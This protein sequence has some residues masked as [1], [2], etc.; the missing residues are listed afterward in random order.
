MRA[1]R[2]PYGGGR[3]ERRGFARDWGRV[4]A[5]WDWEG[6]WAF[7]VDVG[8]KRRIAA[9]L[10]GIGY[11]DKAVVAAWSFN[12][13]IGS[14]GARLLVVQSD[15]ASRQCVSNGKLRVSI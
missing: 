8:G 13:A 11:A 10:A 2:T 14:Y 4:W 12:P 5:F 6:G 9:N 7:I 1:E 3:W 15:I